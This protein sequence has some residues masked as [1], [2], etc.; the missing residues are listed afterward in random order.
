MLPD[1]SIRMHCSVDA[2]KKND[3]ICT[4]CRKA[5]V[6]ITRATVISEIGVRSKHFNDF[7]FGPIS[8]CTRTIMA[9]FYA[10]GFACEFFIAA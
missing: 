7:I 6:L 3:R 4:F 8:R 2:L 1:N 10:P 5:T 9:S